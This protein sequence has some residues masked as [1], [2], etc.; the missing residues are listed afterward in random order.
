MGQLVDNIHSGVM[1]EGSYEMTFDAFD[2]MSGVYFIR[3][4]YLNGVSVQKVMLLK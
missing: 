4:E 1:T 2:M 3:A